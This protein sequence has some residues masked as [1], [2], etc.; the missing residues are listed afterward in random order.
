MIRATLDALRELLKEE[1]ILNSRRAT[2]AK[3]GNQEVGVGG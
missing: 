2:T 3:E 1:S